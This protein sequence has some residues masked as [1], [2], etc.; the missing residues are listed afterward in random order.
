MFYINLSRTL[1]LLFLSIALFSEVNA[2]PI[3]KAIP[4]STSIDKN[5]FYS[6]SFTK[7]VFL[8]SILTAE[9]NRV[10]GTFYP[11]NTSL[12]IETDIPNNEANTSYQL[13]LTD[14]QAQCHTTTGSV[15]DLYDKFVNVEI[16]GKSIG[17]NE[18]IKLDDFKSNQNGFKSSIHYFN[19]QFS[20]LPDKMK[21]DEY[22][23]RCGGS[24]SVRLEFTI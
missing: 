3:V 22:L 6:E 11:V 9:Y 10:I 8:P 5:K 23:L 20:S 17:I 4:V 16:D 18:S 21:V 12:I 1:T 15:V 19:L 7:V 14:N 2:A 13:I 24:I